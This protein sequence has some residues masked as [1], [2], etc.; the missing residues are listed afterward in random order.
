MS[1]LGA[2]TD[3]EGNKFGLTNGGDVAVRVIGDLTVAASATSAITN[4]TSPGT[5]DTEFSMAL[6]ADVKSFIL[7]ARGKTKI[8]FTLV[9]GE[10]IPGGK[11][12]ESPQI[13]LISA[14]IYLQVNKTSQIIE[15]LA[16]S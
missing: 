8:Q 15:L 4:T 2:R 10:T 11:S 16:W 9:S 12:F 3:N 14:T 7:R 13:K 1:P 5:A 6:P